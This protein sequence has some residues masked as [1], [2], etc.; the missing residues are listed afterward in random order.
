MLRSVL[1]LLFLVGCGEQQPEPLYL[2]QEFYNW[3]CKDYQD[4]SEVVITTSTCDEEVIWL[5]AEV[6]LIDGQH[7]KRKLDSAATEEDECN[8]E[9]M[10][11]LL[12]NYCT[13]VD[14]VTLTAYVE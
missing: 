4:Q 3:G 5:V 10:I 6:H 7:W 13:H 11:P 9:T 2:T 14:G 1:S 8:W 12:D